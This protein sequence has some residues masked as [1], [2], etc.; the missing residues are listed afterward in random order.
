MEEEQ[1]IFTYLY[2]YSVLDDGNLQL[3]LFFI[4]NNPG[5]WEKDRETLQYAL[6]NGIDSKDAKN[7]F[8]TFVRPLNK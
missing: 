7:I 3:R 8:K 4:S 6:E 1:N 2:R 5:D